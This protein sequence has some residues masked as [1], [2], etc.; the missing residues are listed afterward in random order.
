MK[1]K[2]NLDERVYKGEML[3]CP[4]CQWMQEATNPDGVTEE[5]RLAEASSEGYEVWE[6]SY[7]RSFSGRMCKTCGCIFSN[8]ITHTVQTTGPVQRQEAIR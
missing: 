3:Q 6:H 2:L 5:W 4:R 8:T 1:A 7:T